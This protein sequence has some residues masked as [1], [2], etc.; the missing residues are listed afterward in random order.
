[1]LFSASHDNFNMKQKERIFMTT[2]RFIYFVSL[3]FIPLNLQADQHQDGQSIPSAGPISTQIQLCNLN[4]GR[5]MNDYDKIIQKYFKWSKKHDVEVVF[6]RT[7]P[8]FSHADAS[9]PG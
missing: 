2:L 5:T 3:A 7:V 4:P 9:H 8:L 6:T 1:V